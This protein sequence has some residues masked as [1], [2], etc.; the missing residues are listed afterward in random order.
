MMSI[1]LR[2][3]AIFAKAWRTYR[4]ALDEIERIDALVP[5]SPRN[6]RCDAVM[7]QRILEPANGGSVNDAGLQPSAKADAVCKILNHAVEAKGDSSS[8]R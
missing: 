7:I 8:T 3:S 1:L 6:V 4:A 2:V 5:T